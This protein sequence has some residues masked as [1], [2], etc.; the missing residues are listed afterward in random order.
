MDS[1]FISLRRPAEK[2]AIDRFEED[3]AVLVNTVSF[4]HISLPANSL[5]QGVKPGDTLVKHASGWYVDEAESEERARRIQQ[6]LA[7]IR[8]ANRDRNENI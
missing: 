4:E 3:W 6:R 2:W 8:A 1:E 5:P 7:R